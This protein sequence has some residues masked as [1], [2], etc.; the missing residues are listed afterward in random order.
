M[1]ATIEFNTLPTKTQVRLIELS[2]LV[3]GVM[4][5]ETK[6]WKFATSTLQPST[7]TP[8]IVLEVAQWAGKE[9]IYLYTICLVTEQ[10][11]LSKI[12]IAFSEAKAMKKNGRA[13]PRLNS[14]SCCFYVGSSEKM[15]QR[16][17]EHLG[18]GTQGT[19]ALQLAHWASSFQIEL[20][21]KCARYKAGHARE[22]YQALEDT[23]WDEMSPMF[24]RKGMK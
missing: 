2:K 16:L 21:F 15:H 13:Y 5:I 22:V 8:T 10:C 14:E 11:D 23:L 17:K 7:E 19:Y 9:N 1:T 18:Y 20:E 12:R 3:D 4:P 6:T 24:G